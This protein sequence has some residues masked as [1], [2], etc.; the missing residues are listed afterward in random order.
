MP[1]TGAS[2]VVGAKLVVVGQWGTSKDKSYSALK[3]LLQ[4]HGLLI[5]TLD[6]CTME[7]A[8]R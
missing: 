6:Y 4:S 2:F 5:H 3:Y 8:C 1:R 7:F